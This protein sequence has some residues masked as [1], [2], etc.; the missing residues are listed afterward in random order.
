MGDSRR[1][2]QSKLRTRL[3]RRAGSVRI[4]IIGSGYVGLVAAACFAELGHEVTCVDNDR[5]KIEL[6]QR[7]EVREQIS[8]VLQDSLLSSGTIRDNIAFGQT[9]ATDEEVSAAARTANADEF[10]RR[11]PDGYD[12]R[13]GERRTILSGGQKPCHRPCR[14]GQRTYVDCQRTHKRSRCRRRAHRHQR[15]GTGGSPMHHA[16]HR[17]PSAWQ[18]AL[19][20]TSLTRHHARYESLPVLEDR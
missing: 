17:A 13:V 19:T 15:A 18:I 2:L 3:S 11:L 6:P 7:G 5:Q 16:R 1:S 14:A 9:D 8:L 4:A 12:T 10:I 20:C